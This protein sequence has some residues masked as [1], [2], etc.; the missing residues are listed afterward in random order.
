MNEFERRWKLG[1]TAAHRAEPMETPLAPFGFATRVVAQW[2][3]RPSPSNLSLWQW[4]AWRVFKV[5]VVLTIV[6]LLF[7][8]FVELGE[9]TV[10]PLA[11]PTVEETVTDSISML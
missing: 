7:N 5:V 6:A 8:T 9:P 1:A 10:S 11:A 4:H 3:S 2:Q